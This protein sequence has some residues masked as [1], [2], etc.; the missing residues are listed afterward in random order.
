[1]SHFTLINLLPWHIQVMTPSGRTLNIGHCLCRI[2][3][4]EGTNFA[5][6]ACLTLGPSRGMHRVTL[7]IVTLGTILPQDSEFFSIKLH[8]ETQSVGRL[9]VNPPDMPRIKQV[10]ENALHTPH[11]HIIICTSFISSI[12]Y[13]VFIV[14]QCHLNDHLC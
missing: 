2:S 4:L 6:I 5:A 14:L 3:S 7:P 8:S 9:G 13:Y 12:D 10:K 11:P 1:M